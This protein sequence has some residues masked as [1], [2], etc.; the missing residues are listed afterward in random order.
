MPDEEVLEPGAASPMAGPGTPEYFY[1][2]GGVGEVAIHPETGDPL[3][4]PVNGAPIVQEHPRVHAQMRV[5]AAN[6]RD[7]R[8]G[9]AE[10]EAELAAANDRHAEIVDHLVSQQVN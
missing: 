10:A 8:A 7:D 9:L 3:I 5:D 4:N 1:A 2:V 6:A